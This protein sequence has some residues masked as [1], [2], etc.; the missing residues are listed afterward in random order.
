MKKLLLLILILISLTTK[1]FAEDCM[2]DKIYEQNWNAEVTTGMRVRDIPC[3]ESSKVL[4]TVAVG[5]IIKIIAKTDGY[6][7]VKLKNG[8]EG[9]SGQWLV[10]KTN[11]DFILNNKEKESLYDITGHQ[12][13]T[14]IRYLKEKKIINGYEDGTFK[15]D[16]TIN[17]AEFVKIIVGAVYGYKA[18]EDKSTSDIY[19]ASDLNFSDI[20]SGE[21]YI[22]YLRKAVENN[23]IQG[24][25][26]KT[27]K[28]SNTINLVE[29]AK[30][31]SR[32]YELTIDKSDNSPWYKPYITAMQNQNYIPTSFVKL[33]QNVN[34]GEMA[35]MTWRIM[36][37][38][39]NMPSKQFQ[40]NKIT[41]IDNSC[42]DNKMPS[43]INMKIVR[44]TWL[45]WYN[46][47]R[48]KE[49][50]NLYKYN[51]NL[52]YSATQWSEYSN[53]IGVMSHKRPGQTAYYDYNIITKWFKNLGIT[54][55]NINRVT[56]S[57]NIG[58]GTYKCDLSDCTQDF[59]NAIKPTF[60]FYMN[61]KG[62][63]N[64]SHY[65][66]IM[67][68]YFKEIGI[69]FSINENNNTVYLTVHYGTEL[70]NTPSNICK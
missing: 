23:L 25:S 9:W 55:K 22:P 45:K 41:N 30:I 65:N 61:E 27:F 35:E 29:S 57:E 58:Y 67:N 37:K 8:T 6:Y 64:A 3:M 54:F 10:K 5:E 63:K 31:L 19:S 50:L 1:T 51:E 56:Y 39:N 28:A 4:T 26:D 21:W 7:K 68:K 46:D 12:Y 24:Y 15:A 62:T 52:N 47:A 13:E 11:K 40:F 48:S 36:E 32:A 70:T 20:Q 49:G 53:S 43:N 34:R 14:A 59:I 2:H 33:N 69:G 44:E 18:E 60:N 42:I 66:S 38:I 16:K 17:R